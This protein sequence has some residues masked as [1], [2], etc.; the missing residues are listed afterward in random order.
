MVRRG[1]TVRVR[2]RALSLSEPPANGR[3]FVAESDTVEHLLVK[4][5][6]DGR[7]GNAGRQ[8]TCKRSTSGTPT[9]RGLDPGTG[10]GDR[11]GADA[12][13]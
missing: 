7:W 3:F 2:Q 10:S 1:S 13:F 6:L 8:N 4:E 9:V 5:G 11:F 12:A